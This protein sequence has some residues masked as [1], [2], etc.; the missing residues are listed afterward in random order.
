M[1]YT[2][3]D[4]IRMAQ[5]SE[6]EQREVMQ[7]CYNLIDK[8]LRFYMDLQEDY[9]P[10]INLWIMGTYVHKSFNTYPYLF[11]NATRGSGKSRLLRLIS[12]LVKNGEMLGSLTEATLFRNCGQKTYC[13]DEFENVRAK[14]LQA[15]RELLNSGYKKGMRVGR[16]KEVVAGGIKSYITEYF[17]VYTPIC[18]AN[19]NGM[20]DILSDRCIS[21]ILDKSISIKTKLIEGEGFNKEFN[22]LLEVISVGCACR[23]TCAGLGDW[24]NY[25]MSAYTTN[26]TSLDTQPTTYPTYTTNTNITINTTNN[27]IFKYINESNICGRDLELFFPILIMASFVSDELF[28][29][30]LEISKE[31]IQTKKENDKSESSDLILN[32]YLAMLPY[33]EL[34]FIPIA[35]ITRE[36]KEYVGYDVDWIKPEWISHALKRNNFIMESKRTNEGISKRLDF[37]L[38]RAK[39]KMM[40]GMETDISSGIFKSTKEVKKDDKTEI[41]LHFELL[42]SQSPQND[43][44]FEEWRDKFKDKYSMTE[45][46]MIVQKIKNE[47]LVF[48]PSAGLFKKI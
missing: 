9:Y 16:Q 19:I 15:L 38:I 44:L 45:F 11:F 1:E 42:S 33:S 7:Y 31:L 14:E 12:S 26:T 3:T 8:Y 20:N 30:V 22:D 25:V 35:K 21:F 17:E 5:G 47:G 46:E 4:L 36:F 10:I 24:N 23:F 2:K 39:L 27:N 6:G 18:M 41:M 40:N 28:F 48:E 34:D 37:A 32:A 43:V 13:I 29:K